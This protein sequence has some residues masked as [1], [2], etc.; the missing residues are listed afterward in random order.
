MAV[1]VAF[2]EDPGRTLTEA[3]VF[4]AS[5]PVLHN[6]ILTLLHERLAYPEPGRYWLAKDG[7]TVVGVAF[8][9]PLD[10]AAT[11]TPIC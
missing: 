9:S 4:L 3:G 7:G 6:L 2:S 5:Y 11:L 10:F 1:D 8:Q